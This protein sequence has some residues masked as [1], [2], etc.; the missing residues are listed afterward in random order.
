MLTRQ[1]LK[2][3]ILTILEELDSENHLRFCVKIYINAATHYDF[4]NDFNSATT[5]I[6]RYCF[7]SPHKFTLSDT[8]LN[9]DL[10]SADNKKLKYLVSDSFIKEN[11]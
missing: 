3:Y 4:Y 6:E 8:V 5:A 2:E 9:I 10:I 1:N 11:Y 7:L